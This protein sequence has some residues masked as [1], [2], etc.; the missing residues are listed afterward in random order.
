MPSTATITGRK[1]KP[2][3]SA[4]PGWDWNIKEP[5]FPSF[6]AP[7]C[8]PFRDSPIGRWE[9]RL[10]CKVEWNEVDRS[11]LLSMFILCYPSSFFLL[12]FLWDYMSM[13]RSIWWCLKAHFSVVRKFE[14]VWEDHRASLRSWISEGGIWNLSVFLKYEL[15]RIRNFR[16]GNK[17]TVTFWN[18]WG[19][20]YRICIYC[21]KWLER[22]FCFRNKDIMKHKSM[23]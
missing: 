6:F 11:L 2:L 23:I 8:Y 21:R 1:H 10:N 16:V 4:C 18:V 13:I 9:A 20:E 17:G 15:L 19:L 3:S 5:F 14:G 22:I 12:A 7:I